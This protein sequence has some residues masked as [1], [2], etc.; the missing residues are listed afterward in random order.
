M[1][2]GSELEKNFVKFSINQQRVCKSFSF[3]EVNTL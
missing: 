1:Q 2:K 3:N